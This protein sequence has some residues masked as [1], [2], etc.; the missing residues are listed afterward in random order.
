MS[1]TKL[2]LARCRR[3]VKEWGGDRVFVRK[4]AGDSGGEGLGEERGV[5]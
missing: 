3:R 5:V 4:G 2:R 1:D